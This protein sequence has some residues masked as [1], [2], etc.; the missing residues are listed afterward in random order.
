MNKNVA[1]YLVKNDKYLGLNME[2]AEYI[3]ELVYKGIEKRS[4][5]MC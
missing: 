3:V 5:Q 4:I 1:K 2:Q